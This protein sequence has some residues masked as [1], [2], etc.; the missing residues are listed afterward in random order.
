MKLR[1]LLLPIP[2]LLATPG[3]A[4]QPAPPEWAQD[5]VWYQLFPERFRNSDSSNDP[6]HASLEDPASV[7][8]SWAVAPWTADWYARAPWEEAIGPDFY[9]NGVFNR[10]LGGDLQGVLDKL[11]YL[12]SLGV[13]AVYFNPVFYGASLHKYDGAS[14][15]HVDPYFG[16]D[17]EGDLAQIATETADPATWRNTAADSLFFDLLDA[18]HARGIKVVIDGVFNHSGTHFF[19]FQDLRRN[20]QASPYRDWYN[21]T[22]WDDPA[23]PDTSEFDWEGWWG[24]K[25][26]PV[27][28][29]NADTTDLAAG[30]RQYVMDVTRRWM[31]P[32]GDGDP[33]DGIDGWRLDVSGEVPNGFWRAWNGLV[34]ELNPDAYTSAEEWGDARAYLE[35]A[36][37]Q[38]VMNYHAFAIPVYEWLA[39]GAIG[40]EEFGRR[41]AERTAAYPPETARALMNLVDSHDTDRLASMIVNSGNGKN[42]DRDNS[43]RGGRMDVAVRAPNEA[44]RDVQRMVVVLQATNVAAPM[45]YYGD[46]AGMWGADDPDVRKPMVWPD[47]AFAPEALDPLGRPRT[48][49]PVAFNHELFD[50]YRSALALR[51]GSTALRRGTFTLLAADSAANTLAYARRDG[52]EELVVMVNAS[53]AAQRVRLPGRGADS[54][55]VPIFASR[56]SL[57]E[58]P[59]L[60]ITL[61]E[62]GGVVFSN[63]IPARTAVVFRRVREGDVRPQGVQE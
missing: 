10:R 12:D 26:L 17:P 38:S 45:I 11:G 52:D 22:R 47:L 48:P 1:Y 21:V 54:P 24:F 16:P 44:E 2:Y 18:A 36:G 29:D 28:K 23:T 51:K 33:S 25:G 15:H 31:D 13:T 32:D 14:M 41:L 8:E 60:N 53:D 5:A 57:A 55:L 62:A 61:P 9:E 59:S 39:T 27:F 46:E 3:V 40:A 37:F 50:F 56:G 58:I 30:P 7:P 19:A 6:T 63:E 34:R 20:Q 49:D 42:Y 4:A 43:P 35:E